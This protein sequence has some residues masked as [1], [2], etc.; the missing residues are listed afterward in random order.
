MDNFVVRNRTARDNETEL[1]SQM[2]DEQRRE[3]D[4]DGFAAEY[5]SIG[6]LTPSVENCKRAKDIIA[7]TLFQILPSSRTMDR[8]TKSLYAD[9]INTVQK[10]LGLRALL[11]RLED[12]GT[13]DQDAQNM[14]AAYID[15]I[16]FAANIKTPLAN[17]EGART[18]GKQVMCNMMSMLQWILCAWLP[19][20]DK[21]NLVHAA[22]DMQ[23]IRQNILALLTN[24]NGLQRS[25]LAHNTAEPGGQVTKQARTD[26]GVVLSG[27]NEGGMSQASAPMEQRKPPERCFRC[28]QKFATSAWRCSH[29]LADGGSGGTPCSRT[30]CGGCVLLR[31]A[32]R[33]EFCC[34]VHQ[35]RPV[36][37]A[38]SL[39]P[40]GPLCFYCPLGAAR[41]RGERQIRCCQSC[42][43]AL[44]PR[45]GVFPEAWVRDTHRQYTCS[46]C[47]GAREDTQ[48]IKAVLLE[49]LYLMTGKKLSSVEEYSKC[50]F[51]NR[52]LK[53][54]RQAASLFSDYVFDVWR[55]GW[56]DISDPCVDILLM[57]NLCLHENGQDVVTT[58]SQ[59]V[60]MLRPSSASRKAIEFLGRANSRE[61][62]SKHRRE[63][64]VP[65]QSP[66]TIEGVDTTEGKPEP[67]VRDASCW[68][69]WIV[70]PSPENKSGPPTLGIWMFDA[71]QCGP[72]TSLSAYQLS[73][74]ARSSKFSS[75]VL[76][77]RKLSAECDHDPLDGPVKMLVEAYGSRKRLKLFDVTASDDEI[78]T[79]LLDQKFDIILDMTGS[80]YG[81]ID[82]VLSRP[83]TALQ[84]AYLGYPGPAYGIRDY[85]VTSPGL[86]NYQVRSSSK[87][88]PFATTC[89]MYPPVGWHNGHTGQA[90]SL[91]QDAF[92]VP[93]VA[94]RPILAF[95]G[96]ADKIGRASV[97]AWCD[98]LAGTGDGPNGA[99]LMLL[100]GSETNVRAVDRWRIEYNDGRSGPGNYKE[101]IPPS[102]IFWT[103]YRPKE[104]FWAFLEAFRDCMVSVSCLESY[105]VHT[106]VSDVLS[107]CVVHLCMDNASQDWPQ[108]VAQLLVKQTGLSSILVA[109]CESDFVKKGIPLLLNAELRQA[110]SR[111]LLECRER[112]VGF[113][114]RDRH[115]TNLENL[116]LGAL[117]EA[118]R[119]RGDV[120]QMKDI[121]LTKDEPVNPVALFSPEPALMPFG[122]TAEDQFQRFMQ[123]LTCKR[124]CSGRFKQWD[125]MFATI[126]RACHNNGFRGMNLVGIG[127]SSI[128]LHAVQGE[129]STQIKSRGINI[130]ESAALKITHFGIRVR[131][132]NRL[133]RDPNI[134]ALNVWLSADLRRSKRA[135]GMLPGPLYVWPDESCAGVVTGSR[136]GLADSGSS[137]SGA[138]PRPAR[139]R[140]AMSFAAYSFIKEGPMADD[141]H[142]LQIVDE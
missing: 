75:V 12:T 25:E 74:L 98:M 58:E 72:T 4:A 48:R 3:G 126:V 68:P 77:G 10:P 65:T 21:A 83:R 22:K 106:L 36:E 122:E 63:R 102:R 116:L 39:F 19:A 38:S 7:E 129:P 117:H 67:P 80:S 118:R 57:I 104:S 28:Y 123:Q 70:P 41:N 140:L 30:F 60:R 87:R 89:C 49:Y 59:C 34:P 55:A 101:F 5:A 127:S 142:Y 23:A 138:V 92:D 61:L 85:T 136:Q 141:Q 29:V 132:E 42:S 18:L 113:Y 96:S 86:V 121:D 120:T 64:I 27:V 11:K 35:E 130:G 134:I 114:A 40:S 50:D 78:Y 47:L 6:P 52:R 88:G 84:I 53:D 24:Q 73:Q 20:M 62:V 44:C 37:P 125:R 135:I 95:W 15:Q 137:G 33:A 14:A 56:H 103:P 43:K 109:N 45:C 131:Q 97:F 100:D 108:R 66:K 99:I 139:S 16:V 124:Q 51:R 32:P 115:V 26:S 31:Q 2:P 111:H 9:Q 90:G 94:G 93:G 110:A 13:S 69:E 8:L 112:Q 46:G 17:G 119:V 71:A 91:S 76:F 81:N 54:N 133:N 82:G 128:C 79:W 107:C 105:D 1:M